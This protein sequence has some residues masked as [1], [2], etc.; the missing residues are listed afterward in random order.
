MWSYGKQYNEYKLGSNPNQQGLESKG[1]MTLCQQFSIC[2][3][4]TA[5]KLLKLN[6]KDTG[7]T[8]F[9]YEQFEQTLFSY[10]IKPILE[11]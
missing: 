2:D 10:N 7:S 5:N 6:Q 1:F 11:K 9:T 4:T 3:V 8:G